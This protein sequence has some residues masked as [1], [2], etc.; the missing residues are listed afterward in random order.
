VL[1]K[2]ELEGYR[3]A[4]D[5]LVVIAH[6]SNPVENLAI[7]DLRRIYHGDTRRWSE[8]GGRDA[9]I[10]PVLP[11]A[12]SDVAGFFAQQVMG[13][14]PL[15]AP[16]VYATSDSEVVARVTAERGAIGFVS[17]AWAD[18]GG[19]VMRL[20]SLTGLPYWKPDLEAVY[21]GEYPLTRF[22]APR[23][24]GSRAASSRT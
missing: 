6:P 2:L 22:F 16:V 5:A 15:L 9:P 8:V 23:V 12:R 1:G 3:F 20:A 11:S 17:L 24:R 13:G 18:R 10:V 21:K 7:E 4:R 19:K 14:E